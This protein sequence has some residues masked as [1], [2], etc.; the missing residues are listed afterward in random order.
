MVVLGAV[1]AVLGLLVVAVLLRLTSSP[2]AA[3]DPAGQAVPD[4][5]PTASAPASAEPDREGGARGTGPEQAP[6]AESTGTGSGVCPAFPRFPDESCT[7]Y[8][9]TGVTLRPCPN[10][11]TEDG[12]TFDGCRFGPDLEVLARGVTVTRS[13]VE[14]TVFASYL[15]DWSLGDLRLVDVEIDGGQRVVDG[16]SAAIGNDDYTC[17][18]CHIHGSERGANLGRNVHIEESYLHGWLESP[19]AHQTAIGSN[20]GNGFTIIHN[21]LECRTADGCSAALSLYEDFSAIDDVLIQNN[22]FN[23]NGSYCTYAGQNG[24]NIRYIDNV[25]GTRFYPRCGQYGAVTDFQTNQGNVW[26]GNRYPDGTEVA[27]S[28]S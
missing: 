4:P 19:G 15:T 6:G 23:T 24:T 13:L 22:L 28:G 3:D 9:H 2:P 7:G 1:G 11:I 27:P 20:G 21:H 25:F 8:R 5:T 10:V 12:A 18:R 26:R 16:R 14:G 17:I